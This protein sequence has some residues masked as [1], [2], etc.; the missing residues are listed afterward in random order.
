MAYKI[1]LIFLCIFIIKNEAIIEISAHK[2]PKCTSSIPVLSINKLN[3]KEC[4]K[5]IE[6]EY[7]ERIF[8]LQ[9]VCRSCANKNMEGHIKIREK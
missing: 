2:I 5:Y 8:P 6:D 3:T 4:I 7:S 9:F 1:N